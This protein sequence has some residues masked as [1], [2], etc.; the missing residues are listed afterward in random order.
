MSHTFHIPRRLL[1]LGALVGALVVGAAT[2][3]SAHDE[4]I[5]ADPA[6]GSQIDALPAE[7]TLTFSG[8]LLDEPGATEVVVTDAERT[9]L[10]SGDPVIDGT[11]LTQPLEGAAAGEVTVI[12]RVVSSDGHPVSDEYTFTVGDG[13][14]IAPTGSAASPTASA[15]GEPSMTGTDVTPWLWI[16]ALVAVLAGAAVVLVAVQRSTRN[17]RSRE[18]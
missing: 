1:V 7:L 3:A 10:T 8:V 14:A 6:A 18:D 15:P 4:L 5:G 12:W 17:G 11:R 16:G 9:D 13:T 2:P